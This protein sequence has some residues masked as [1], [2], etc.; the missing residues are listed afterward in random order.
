MKQNKIFVEIS[1]KK[2]FSKY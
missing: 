2:Y 1:K